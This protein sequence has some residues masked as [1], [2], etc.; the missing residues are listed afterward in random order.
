LS[1]QGKR[2]AR[3]LKEKSIKSSMEGRTPWVRLEDQNS[4]KKYQKTP[5]IIVKRRGIDEG[6]NGSLRGE[7][8][9]R[10]Q[11]TVVLFW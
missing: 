7:K 8:K 9:Q 1:H 4:G 3:N 10:Q 5:L 11:M 6:Q 2:A